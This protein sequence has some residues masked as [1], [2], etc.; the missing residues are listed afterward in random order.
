M[1]NVYPNEDSTH[2][3]FFV[4]GGRDDYT[5]Q[6]EGLG[7]IFHCFLVM[8]TD[9]RRNITVE[10]RLHPGYIEA[11][12]I[13]TGLDE[14]RSTQEFLAHPVVETTSCIDGDK[15]I[16]QTSHEPYRDSMKEPN[17]RTTTGCFRPIIVTTTQE[18]HNIYAIGR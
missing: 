14:P 5:E 8:P 2:P 7:S 17:R 1:H 9:T 15:A 13:A 18:M 12:R 4:F 6:G 16:S 10:R 11:L 3:Q